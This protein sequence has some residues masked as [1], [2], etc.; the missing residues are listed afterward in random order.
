MKANITK[1]GRK[2]AP[3]QNRY[4]SSQLVGVFIEMATSNC[5]RNGN[6]PSNKRD[7]AAPSTDS[8]SAGLLAITETQISNF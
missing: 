5:G 6:R 8:Y 3:R 7:C 4:E 2:C 1:R